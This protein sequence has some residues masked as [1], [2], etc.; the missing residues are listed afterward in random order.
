MIQQEVFQQCE[1]RQCFLWGQLI[2]QQTFGWSDPNMQRGSV[3]V[4]WKPS[5][6][7]YSEWVDGKKI[8]NCPSC[9]HGPRIRAQ[10]RSH[11]K[12]DSWRWLL[13]RL[14]ACL[15]TLESTRGPCTQQWLR[16]HL[17]AL[18]PCPCDD[19]RLHL[20]P[21]SLYL[22]PNCSPH[23]GQV[24]RF[25]GKAFLGSRWSPRGSGKWLSLLPPHSSQTEVSFSF[26]HWKIAKTT[27]YC[28]ANPKTGNGEWC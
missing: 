8:S 28:T 1:W 15:T 13:L 24:T 17:L 10:A 6:H 16:I 21:S 5:S 14:P 27:P 3:T 2:Q 23:K 4:L 25:H 12:E 18:P 11:L 9:L 26:L 19:C 22:P 20:A 7:P